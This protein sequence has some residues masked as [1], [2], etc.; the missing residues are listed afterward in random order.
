[1]IQKD[2][3]CW[4]SVEEACMDRIDALHVDL[5]T[6]PADRVPRLQGELTALRWL[7]Q[8]AERPAPPESTSMDL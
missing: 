1:V 8:Q 4:P 6:A 7:L 2:N 3:V 5:E